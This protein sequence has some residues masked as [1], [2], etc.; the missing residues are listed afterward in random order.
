[1]HVM[2]MPVL[3][4]L[5]VTNLHRSATG[6]NSGQQ[7]AEKQVQFRTRRTC[8]NLRPARCYESHAVTANYHTRKEGLCEFSTC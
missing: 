2:T 4:C 8:S 1:M 3:A 6:V 7:K 5:F